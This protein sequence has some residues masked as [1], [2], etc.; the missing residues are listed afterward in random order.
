[1]ADANFTQHPRPTLCPLPQHQKKEM[2]EHSRQFETTLGGHTEQLGSAGNPCEPRGG[3]AH[4][5]WVRH[6]TRHLQPNE[7]LRDT[8]ELDPVDHAGGEDL[9]QGVESI[10]R[11]PPPPRCHTQQ[12][13]AHRPPTP[14]TGSW[15]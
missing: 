7:V 15:M 2:A 11:S 9:V 5:T 3:G 10:R 4:P 6:P 13:S 12:T 8:S 14:V 1:V